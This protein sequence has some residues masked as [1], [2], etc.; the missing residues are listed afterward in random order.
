MIFQAPTVDVREVSLLGRS[1]GHHQTRRDKDQREEVSPLIQ[2]HVDLTEPDRDK[3][4][5][6]NIGQIAGY[7]LMSLQLFCERIFLEE[8]CWTG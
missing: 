3:I 6:P 7:S 2:H 5:P 1:Y 8:T 4:I